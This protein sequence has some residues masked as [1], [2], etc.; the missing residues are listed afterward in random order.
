MRI[1]K[2]EARS[3]KL[4]IHEPEQSTVQDHVPIFDL[5]L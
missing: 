5:V 2:F 3:M 4:E 1:S